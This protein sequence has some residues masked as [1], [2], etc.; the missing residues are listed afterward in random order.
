LQPFLALD[1]MQLGSAHAIQEQQIEGKEDELIRAAFIH[2]GLEPTE[3]RHA[4]AVES[5]ELAVEIGRLHL[6]RAK[7]LDRPLV[8]MRPIEARP[9]QQLDVAAIDAGVH[10][11]AVVLDLVQQA[12]AR[13]C[14]VYH[15]RE[16]R[17]DP[18]RRPRSRSH[19][20]S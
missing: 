10:A 1:Q 5:A 3:Y 6:Q 18:H 2:G 4:V 16:L 9:S 13:W 19:A 7:R 17:L 15:A 8:A 11:V 20:A 14:L 12:A